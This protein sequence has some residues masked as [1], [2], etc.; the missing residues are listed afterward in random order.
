[1]KDLLSKFHALQIELCN[2]LLERELAVDLC[3]LALLTGEHLLLL[4]PPGTA[5]S[6]LIRSLCSRIQGGTYFERLLT[7]FS[8]PE[9][10]FGPL[11][12]KALENDRYQRILTGTLV[13]AHIGFLDEIFKANSAILNSLLSL[14]NERVYHECGYAMPVPLL[15]LFGA[16]N[17]TP[18]DSS[19]NALYDRFLLRATV[20]YVSDDAS[21]RQLLT[22]QP[23]QPN[24]TITLDEIQAA[25][26]A[27]AQMP[28]TGDACEAIIAI[29]H[30]LEAEGIAASD[31]RWRSCAKLV[32]AKA[33]LLGDGQTVAEHAEV[34]TH[35]LWSDPNQIR[36]VERVVSKV[37][38]P[39]NLEAVELEDAAKDLYD[40]KPKPDAQNQTTMLEPLLRQLGDIHTRLETRIHAAPPQR[41]QRAQ[42][43]L[44]KIEGWHR[45]LS[46]MALR[47]LSL[48]HM[49]PGA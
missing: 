27:V 44:S 29:R 5:K 20:P 35:A 22:M 41:S 19:L 47:S 21:I 49:A 2:N 43:A 9:E 7:K 26:D 39:L 23:Q 42:Q 13:E 40:Q 30:G 4:G 28:L 34:L 11:S 24:A 38:N 36:V 37:A 15:S 8:T 48:L 17:E 12:L 16:S 32:K 14:I 1:M 31:R 46:Q 25:Q 3:L 10:I 33:W 45:D 6:L 18:E